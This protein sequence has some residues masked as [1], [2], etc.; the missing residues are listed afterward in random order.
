M[1][2]VPGRHS[3]ALAV[4]PLLCCPILLIGQQSGSRNVSALIGG[5]YKATNFAGGTRSMVGVKAAVV[6]AGGL[7]IGGVG[8]K[9]LQPVDISVG[10]GSLLELRTGYGGITVA[11]RGLLGGRIG[12]S[13]LL[14]VGNAEIRALP[15]GNQ[16]GSDNFLVFE[17]EVTLE[18]PSWNMVHSALGGGFRFVTGVDDLPTLTAADLRGFTVTLMVV[19]GG[20]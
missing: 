20:R 5:I 15:V 4:F 17:P 14:G 10:A 9:V 7:E 8:I 3:I 13:F 18:F 2:S 6:F 11:K 1:I 19:V 16:L 12:A